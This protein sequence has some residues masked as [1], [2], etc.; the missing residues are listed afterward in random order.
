[1]KEFYPKGQHNDPSYGRIIN[2][3]HFNRVKDLLESPHG[4]EIVLGGLEHSNEEAKLF[5]TTV[6]KNPSL[7]SKMMQEEIFGPALPVLTVD[8]MESAIS[9]V[10][11][12][13]QPLGLYI[14]SSNSKTVDRIIDCCPS[15]GVTV[16][17]LL[18]HI[19][20]EGLPFG[21]VGPSGMGCTK[22]GRAG[23]DEFSH[24]RSVLDRGNGSPDL[25]KGVR[26]APHDDKKYNE[27]KNMTLKGANI[28]KF[29]GKFI[30]V[31]IPSVIALG[32]AVS[33]KSRL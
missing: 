15:G 11:D 33:L 17:D 21:G 8:C 18:V 31:G 7:G 14:F 28:K 22:G 4:G 16:N 3:V 32:I 26:Y 29:V 6:V 30:G 9:I 23:F 20:C 2:K 10:R 13:D 12:L 19:A 27:L 24:L 5:P 1:M 25:F